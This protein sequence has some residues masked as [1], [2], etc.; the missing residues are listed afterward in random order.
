MLPKAEIKKYQDTFIFLSKVRRSVKIRYF[1][2]ID[3]REYEKQMQNL[4]DTHLSVAG[5]KKITNPIDIL[6][7]DDFEK[8]LEELGSLRAK[9]DAIS[10]RLTKSISTKYDEN[11][12]F[13][14]SFSKR[15]RTALNEYKDKIINEA[16]YLSKLRDIM[17][18]YQSG[19]SKVAYPERIKNNVHAQAFYGVIS[20]I[21]DSAEGVTVDADFA[22]EIAEGITQIVAKHSQVDWTNNQTIHDRISQD[23]DDLF[24]TY[25]KERGLKLSFDVI[26]KIIDNVKTV[27]LRRF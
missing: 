25:E 12:A 9:A 4:L 27:A 6:N 19:K 22:A 14:E 26:D 13:Y 1:D 8:E 17:E 5:L 2:A 15:I 20:A 7:K 16:E 23:I 10:S 11:P 18:D 24:Y 21:F 3:H